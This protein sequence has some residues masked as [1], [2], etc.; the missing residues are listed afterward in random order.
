MNYHAIDQYV[1]NA[2]QSSSGGALA[3][4]APVEAKRHK[5][6]SVKRLLKRTV[7]VAGVAALAVGGWIGWKF[8]TDAAKI[9]GDKNPLQ[10]LSVFQPSTLAETNGRVNILLAGYSADDPG[11]QG[12]DLTDSIMVVSYDPQTKSAAMIS[13]PRDTW[14]D[15]PGFGYEKINAAYEDG[16]QENF[17]QSGYASGGM[18]LLEE[19]VQQDFGITS[20][21][22]GL[23]DY[24]AFK[25]AV[26]AV[27]GVTVNIQ[28]SDPRGLYDPN[29]DLN[30]PNGEVALNGEE[31]LNL[32][33]ARGDGSGSY[34]FPDGDFDRTQHQQQL[35][36][37]LKDKA[38]SASV[39]SNPIKIAGL[40]DAVGNNFKTNLSIG[41]METLYEDTKGMSDSKIQSVTLNDYQGQDLLTDYTT[42]D[43]EDALIPAA[44]YD[45]F[46]QIQSA[47]QTILGSSTTSQN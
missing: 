21:Y 44:G 13:I 25:D 39:I 28:S 15:I 31:A 27:G 34:G 29:T 32:A 42:P 47:V 37:A 45:N 30:L 33:K 9:T 23:L 35:L 2:P 10:L 3:I 20:N 43:G 17:N 19:V 38:S 14:V 7:F 22:Y 18:G 4:D 11:H 41:D 6:F 8:Y 5:H 24:T 46:S 16:E 26:N 1:M 36:V 12:A 40:A